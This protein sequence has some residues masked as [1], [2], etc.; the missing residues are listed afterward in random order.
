M[1]REYCFPI[2]RLRAEP[3]D[4]EYSEHFL[5]SLEHAHRTVYLS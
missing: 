4:S 5:H 2:V 3:K 1:S